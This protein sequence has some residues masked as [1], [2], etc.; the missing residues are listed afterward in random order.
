M[1]SHFSVNSIY[2]GSIIFPCL[3][4]M[5]EFNKIQFEIKNQRIKLEFNNFEYNKNIWGHGIAEQETNIL[6][7]FINSS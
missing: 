7:S 3:S 1:S 2:S 6:R 4:A 5:Y